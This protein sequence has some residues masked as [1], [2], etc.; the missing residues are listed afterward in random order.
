MIFFLFSIS[1][2]F[3]PPFPS[4]P[5]KSS[6]PSSLV[7][8]T[9]TG[10]FSMASFNF[11]AIARFISFSDVPSSPEAP[12]SIPPCPASITMTGLLSVPSFSV[13]ETAFPDTIRDSPSPAFMSALHMAALQN[14]ILT[15]KMEA[16]AS[17]SLLMVFPPYRRFCFSIRKTTCTV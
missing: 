4:Y 6:S 1:Y 11:R 14:S 16:A 2:R 5:S 3:L 15:R 7:S 8:T 12:A 17:L 9:S 10:Y 13:S